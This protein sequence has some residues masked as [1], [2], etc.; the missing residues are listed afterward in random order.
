MIK[1]FKSLLLLSTL[2]CVALLTTSSASATLLTAKTNV[3]NGYQIYIST[4]DSVQGSSFGA[5]NNWRLTFTDT[6]SLN[7]GTDY[8]L[9]IYAYD[10]G[11]IAGF[12][13]GFSLTGSDHAFSNTLTTLTSNTSNWNGNNSGWG[14]ANSPLVNLGVNSVGPWGFKSGVSSSANWIW[15][16]DANSNDIAYFS[17]KISAQTTVPEPASILLFG[18]GFLGL[19]LMRKAKKAS[20]PQM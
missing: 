16:G 15:A 2:A 5:G 17:T 8:F 14:A 7:A 9:H 13:G 4:N 19:A 1:K 3:D 10:Q 20:L 11:G 12:L 6:T 18:L